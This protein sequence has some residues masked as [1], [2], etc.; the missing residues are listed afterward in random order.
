MIKSQ[1]VVTCRLEGWTMRTYLIAVCL[2]ALLLLTGCNLGSSAEPTDEPIATSPA[3]QPQVVIQSPNEGANF[4]VNQQ[5]NVQITATDSQGINRAQL[6]S[7]GQIV[8]TVTST[9]AEGDTNF[10]GTLDFTPRSTGTYQL[11][12]IAYRGTVASNT[13]QVSV[14]V[15]E[16]QIGVTTRPTTIPGVATSTPSGPNIPNDGVCRALINAPSGLRMRSQPTTT[17]DNIVVVLPDQALA[18]VIG[19][20]GNNSWWKLNYNGQIGWVSAPFTTLYGNCLNVPVEVV[21][22]NTP[23][24]TPTFII[25]PT[26]TPIPTNTPVPSLTPTPGRPDLIVTRIGGE[27]ALTIPQGLTEVTQQYAVTVTNFG[28]GATGQ[29][30]VRMTFNGQQ[31]DLGVVANLNPGESIILTRDLTFTAAGNYDIRVD[32]DPNNVV[33][34]VSDINNRGDISVTVTQQQV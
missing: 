10:T 11:S 30:D 21:A 26:F 7:N 22:I 12:V 32:V 19:R 5:I 9:S 25:A 2:G 31:I 1:H 29:F 17:T 15:G 6:F 8:R 24:P 33:Q 14:T 20:L 4:S 23:I 16:A 34:E 18:P 3:A 27:T 13:A 28:I